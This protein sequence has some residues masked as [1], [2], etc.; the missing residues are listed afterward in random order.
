M[1][2]HWLRDMSL[3][4]QGAIFRLSRWSEPSASGN[5]TKRMQRMWD[6]PK[7]FCKDVRAILGLLDKARGYS[8]ATIKVTYGPLR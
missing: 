3:A 6:T 1:I 2:P 8:N 4:E 7:D 5:P